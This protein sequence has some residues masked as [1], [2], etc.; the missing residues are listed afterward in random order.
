MSGWN[1]IKRD[2]A[3]VAFSNYIREKRNW[4]CEFCNKKCRYGENTVAQLDASHYYSRSHE[5]VRFDEDNVRVLCNPC[6]KRMG[7][8]TKNENGEYD[9]WMKDV[10]GEGGYNELTIRANM[11]KKKDRAM[12]LIIIK[13]LIKT[14]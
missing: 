7:G 11:Y 3:D 4:T 13:E 8:H 14:L 5:N 9:M 10:L 12:E 1:T 2:K 6:H